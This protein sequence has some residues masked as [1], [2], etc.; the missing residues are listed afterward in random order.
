[1]NIQVV[2]KLPRGAGYNL[3]LTYFS[4]DKPGVHPFFGLLRQGERRLVESYFRNKDFTG[5]ASEA[6]AL[7]RI[8]KGKIILIGLGERTK[9]N[10]RKATLCSR[11]VVSLAKQEKL[12]QVNLALA[13]LLVFVLEAQR[14]AQIVTENAFMADYE[15]TRY[16]SAKETKTEFKNLVLVVEAKEMAG[17]QAGIRVGKV[18]GEHVNAAR[19]LGNI[20]GG[21]MTPK[22]LAE[23]ARGAGREHKFKVQVLGVA[24]MKK[25]GMGAVLGVARGSAEEPKFVIM[26]YNGGKKKDKPLV[27][28]GKGV[29]FDTGGLNL[30]PEKGMNDMH[31]DM[32]GGAAVI[33][34]LSAVATLKL[35]L[36]VVGLVPAVENM[37]GSAGYRPGDV[38]KSLS[39]KTIEVLNTDAEG[40]VIL[41]DALAY[42]ARYKPQLVV[43]VATLTGAC[44]VALGTHA[45]GLMTPEPKLQT[46]LMEAGEASGDY[47]WPL[48]MWDEYEDEVKGTFGDV[49]NLGKSGYGGAITGAMFLKQFATGYPWAHLDIAGPMKIVEGQYLS[50]GASGVGTRLLIELARQ[51]ARPALAAVAKGAKKV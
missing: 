26:E 22:L 24:E 49:A 27:F 42:A 44:M 30:K 28:V 8:G 35:P 23:A 40:R 47:V 37:P 18:V 17:A 19:D 14:L 50:K 4:K 1:M 41:A 33:A 6:K 2:T 10:L 39:G 31:L 43:D 48:P 25:L 38:L 7:P 34:A 12:S 21:E 32:S 36:N 11:R 51:R 15:F 29:T 16:R 13:P 45:S 9:W 5:K 46:E 3:A 20:P